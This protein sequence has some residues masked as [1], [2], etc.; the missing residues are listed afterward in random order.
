[1]RH[2]LAAILLALVGACDVVLPVQQALAIGRGGSV[3]RS[4]LPCSGSATGEIADSERVT[5]PL[6]GLELRVLNWN[7]YKYADPGGDADL[8]RFEIGSDLL[9]IQE[10]VFIAEQ[11]AML[12]HRLGRRCDR[13]RLDRDQG[14]RADRAA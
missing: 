6:S 12:V 3:L 4:P 9:L 10:A 13:V 2:A 7:V 1:V 11:Q 8:A 14:G 5:S